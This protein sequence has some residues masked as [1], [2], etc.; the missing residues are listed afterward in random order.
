M[1]EISSSGGPF[2]DPDCRVDF[3]WEPTI[4]NKLEQY[5]IANKLPPGTPIPLFEPPPGPGRCTCPC[6]PA[7][8]SNTLCEA[9]GKLVA[10]QC[11]Q[12][13]LSAGNPLL[14]LDERTM[15]VCVCVC[16]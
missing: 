1:T 12:F 15:A 14:I 10:G 9:Y 7:H 2:P 3:C 8:C 4:A 6:P 13:G 16:P 5:C 11:A